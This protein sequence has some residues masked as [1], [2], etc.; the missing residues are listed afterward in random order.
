VEKLEEHLNYYIKKDP[1]DDK[2]VLRA[3]LARNKTKF[4]IS[5]AGKLV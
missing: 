3:V 5:T 1:S 4:F 2:A